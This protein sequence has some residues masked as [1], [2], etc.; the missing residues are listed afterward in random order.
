[1]HKK[2]LQSVAHTGSLHLCVVHQLTRPVQRSALIEEH[3]HNP[4]SGFNNGNVG[5]AHNRPNERST[6]ARNEDIDVTTGTHQVTSARPPVVINGLHTIRGKTRCGK[7]VSQHLN[8]HPSS[9]LR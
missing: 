9:L 3:V 6:S 1:M 2:G 4:G 5:R 8:H 7:P